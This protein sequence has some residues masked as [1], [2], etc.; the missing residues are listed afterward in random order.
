[1]LTPLLEQ[2]GPDALLTVQHGVVTFANVVAHQLLRVEPGALVGTHLDRWLP[3]RELERVETV[4]AQRAGHYPDLAETYR[5]TWLDAQGVPLVVDARFTHQESTRVFSLRDATESARAE[6]LM[7]RL[8]SLSRSGVGFQGADGL[9]TAAEPVFEELGWRGAYTRIEPTGSVTLRSVACPP[10]DPVGEYAKTLI[11]RFVPRHL[12]PVLHQVVAEGRAIFLDNVPSFLT[13]PVASAQ[14][15]SESLTGSRVYRSAWCPV[16][17]ARGA[18]THLFA[19]A[20]RGMTERDFVA[21]QLF[22]SQL[23]E[24]NELARLRQELVQRERLA[25]VGEMSAVLAHEMRNPLGVVFNAANGLKRTVSGETPLMLLASLLEEAERLRRLTTDL[26]DFARPTTPPLLPVRLDPLLGEVAAAARQEPTAR[27][28]RI[29]VRLPD[30]LPPV[31]ADELLLRR[32]LVNLTVNAL[33]H[34][35][36]GGLVTLSAELAGDTVKLRVENEGAPIPP[37]VGARLFEPFFTT[38]AA[39]S[40]L[41]LAVVKKVM[42]DLH[43]RVELE[44]RESGACFVA[45]VPAAQG[46]AALG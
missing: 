8:A 2:L 19:I 31:L 37:E 38:R 20:G 42:D 24:A 15:L 27:R 6:A 12:T 11:N 14:K 34:V 1:M 13:G 36:E 30:G 43:G 7:S 33:Q 21:L 3:A 25:A 17:D 35:V 46:A 28:A 10:G 45:T 41:G 29:E 39:G 5:L 40:G 44:P 16:R 4:L 32:A 23:G 26:L 22:A 18:I 9:L